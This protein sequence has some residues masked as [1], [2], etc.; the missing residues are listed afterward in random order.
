MNKKTLFQIFLGMTC[1]SLSSDCYSLPKNPQVKAGTAEFKEV[2]PH[3]LE[4]RPSDQAILHYSHFDIGREEKVQFIQKSSSSCVLNRV[5]ESDPSQIFGSLE[6]NGK[7]FLVNPSGIYFGPNSKVNV[8]SLIASTLDISD[9]DFLD[10]TYQ[11]HFTK[12]SL[13]QNEGSLTSI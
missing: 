13:I 11:F 5:L 2:D 3:T 7:V 1:F 8:G 10:E 9:Q 4:I 12:D 6:S